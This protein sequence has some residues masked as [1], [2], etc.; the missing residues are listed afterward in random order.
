VST[1]AVITGI[2]LVSPLGTSLRQTWDALLAGRY[3]TNHAKVPIQFSESSDQ[4]PRVSRLAI[5]AAREA[6]QSANINLENRDELSDTALIVG[7]SKGPVESWLA[8]PSTLSDVEGPFSLGLAQTAVDLSCRLRIGGPRLTTSAACASGLHAL[9]RG[10]MLIESGEASRVL[11]VACEA[12]VHPLF[13]ASFNRL[14][15]LPP[16]GF[17]C[18]PFD[19][20]RAGFLMSEAAAAVVLER[21]SGACRELQIEQYA[22]AAD[23]THLT[24]CDPNGIALRAVL[25]RLI[26]QRP[27][28]LLHAHGTGTLINDEI[29][30]NALNDAAAS[31][32]RPP[33][34]YSHK[35]AL[36]H[37]LGAAGLVSVVLNVAAHRTGMVPPNL[38]TTNPMPAQS[39]MISQKPV[40]REITRSLAVAAGFGGA[41]AAV[42]L[43]SIPGGDS[44]PH[45]PF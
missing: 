19:R 6:L 32:T 24:G 26:D 35:A 29:E 17:G 37:S 14:G 30:I 43:R 13:I 40:R 27:I 7:T 44:L 9:I 21:S 4:M 11:V 12:S 45:L 23:A 33:D 22:I 18:R 42:V 41:I 16:E 8:S 1:T 5:A 10:T 38:R 39:L 20:A 31:S 28:D 34:V 15:V 3:V 25:N 2:G 36:G